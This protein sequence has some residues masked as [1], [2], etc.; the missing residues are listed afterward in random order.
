M[1]THFD[2]NDGLHA[3]RK[4]YHSGYLLYLV[5][6]LYHNVWPG[7]IF[8]AVYMYSGTPLRRTT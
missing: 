7:A 2:T 4:F 6:A 1:F 8:V 5:I 3:G